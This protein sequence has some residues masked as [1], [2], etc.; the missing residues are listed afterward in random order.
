[1][2]DE[3]GMETST[4]PNELTYEEKLNFVSVIA[5]PMASK[6]LSKKLHKLVK[7]GMCLL[8]YRCIYYFSW[9]PN[10]LVQKYPNLGNLSS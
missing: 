5:K 8:V 1:M 3:N 4:A 2:A 10:S 7:K 6:K 9:T